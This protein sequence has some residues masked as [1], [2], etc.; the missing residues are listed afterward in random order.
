MITIRNLSYSY[1]HGNLFEKVSLSIGKAQRVGVVGPNGAGKSTFFR[2]LAG[3]DS[4]VDGSLEI[5]GRVILVPQEVKSDPYMEKS[6]TIREYIDPNQEKEDSELYE[7][8]F[9]LE[10]DSLDLN[11]SPQ[12]L[13]GGQKTKLALIRALIQSPD[14]LLLD[15]PTNFLDTAGK[16]WV[17]KFLGNYHKTFLIISHD[18]DLL[19]AHIDKVLAINPTNKKIEEYKG[20]YS[21]YVK[22]K[23]EHD[24]FLRRKIVNEQKHIKH[25]EKSLIKMQRFTSDKGVRRRTM[26]KKRIE[27]LKANLPELPKEIKNIKLVLPTP[28]PIG[29][30]VISAKHVTKLY[31]NEMILA[32]VSLSILKGERVALIGPN[33]AGKSTFIKILVG[34]IE[35]DDGEVYRNPNLKIGYYSQE[36]ETF[37]YSK[38]IVQMV[39]ES[40]DI[41][42]EKIRTFLGKFNFLGDRIFQTIDTLSGGEKT[43]LSIAMLMLQSYNLLILD[44]PTTY[45]DVMSQRVILEALKSYTGAMLFVSHTEEFVSELQPNRALILPENKVQ[46]WIPELAGKVIE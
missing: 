8:M 34:I 39:E 20:N 19:D 22:L 23:K 41:P 29:E 46:F 35:Q 27:R 14:I 4:V 13:S 37:D 18:L 32:D 44:E 38:T 2:L 10:I 26:L 17:M 31:E 33:G 45:L 5:I 24:K 21:D 28:Q 9:G 36:F 40:S 30:L 43:R 42:Q 15:E 16:S 12:S 1:G 7:M 3:L 25:M 6:S 11:V